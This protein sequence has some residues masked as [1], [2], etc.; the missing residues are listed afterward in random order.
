ML[1]A[2]THPKLAVIAGGH[3]SLETTLAAEL[4]VPVIKK[5]NTGYDFVMRI[6]SLGLGLEPMDGSS[7]AVRVD[8]A[9]GKARQIFLA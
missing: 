4:G 7:G 2:S 1:V 9:A 6:T 8:F 3:Q 5:N